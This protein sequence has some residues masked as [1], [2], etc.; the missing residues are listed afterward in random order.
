MT[1]SAR[2]SSA[3]GTS[4]P[5]ALAVLEPPRTGTRGQRDEADINVVEVLIELADPGP[6]AVGM[7]V[8]VYFRSG[9]QH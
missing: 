6:L 5:S 8:E 3:G 1:S 4:S 7:K 9:S 2:A